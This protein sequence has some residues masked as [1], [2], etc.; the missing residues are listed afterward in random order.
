MNNASPST[1]PD[2]P[3]TPRTGLA[4]GGLAHPSAGSVPRLG[5]PGL[6]AVL[7]LCAVLLAWSWWRLEGYQIADAVEYLERAY[8]LVRGDEMID[9]QAIRSFGFSGLL[10]PLFAVAEFVG[11]D[12]MVWVVHA[13]RLFQMLLTL[14]TVACAVRIGARLGGRGVGYAAGIFLG[15]NPVL[16][17]WGVSPVSGIASALFVALATEQLLR[18]P[19]THHARRG[20]LTGLYLGAAVVMAYQTVVVVVPLVLMTLFR[21][22]KH[23]GTHPLTL[24]A[25]VLAC[26]L[27][28]CFLDLLYYGTFGRSIVTYLLE[29]IGSVGAIQVHRV[30]KFLHIDALSD[31]AKWIYDQG[32]SA[33]NIDDEYQGK[34]LRSL[35][36][37]RQKRERSW[38]L[39]NLHHALTGPGVAL[40]A[41]GVLSALRKLRWS[42]TL[43]LVAIIANVLAMNEKGS[44]DFRLWLPFLPMIAV[45]AGL[46]A[47]VLAGRTSN[48]A[49][50]S[51]AALVLAALVVLG[52]HEHSQRNTRSFGAFWRAMEMVNRAAEMPSRNGGPLHVAC[53]YHWAVFLRES[54]GVNL[55]K[56]PKHLDHWF[57]YT[58]EERLADL[59]AIASL[60]WFITH[61]PI[62]TERPR[63]MEAVNR[64]FAVRGV[65]Y[66]RREFD[67][68]G[69]IYVLAR[70]TG[71]TR[72]RAFYD[73]HEDLTAAEFATDRAPWR[74][75]AFTA[76]EEP[77]RMQLL[78]FDFGRVAGDGLGWIT[79]HW[80]GG[81]L[82]RDLTVIDRITSPS[83]DHAWQNNHE[84][85][86]GMMPTSGWPADPSTPWV[87]SES[88][89][90]V[91]EA[92]PYRPDGP[93]RLIGGSYLRGDRIPADLWFDVALPPSD[94]ADGP[95]AAFESGLQAVRPSDN[96]PVARIAPPGHAP[97]PAGY[98]TSPDGFTWVGAFAIPVRPENR[99]RTAPEPPTRVE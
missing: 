93:D 9:S 23:S 48:A 33:G 55:I 99:L 53:A 44:K 97:S 72:E 85:A 95:A 91:P 12:D 38:Y 86:Y 13:A 45:F 61:L 16:L 75:L 54:G 30:G 94:D 10:I 35:D 87:L 52:V 73:V 2:R 4:G 65:F 41:L 43:L 1:S 64:D 36:A 77:G 51:V 57:Q 56:L 7:A 29:N 26:A 40:V 24:I 89:L 25:G 92:E 67:G 20:L 96:E 17:Q 3:G 88:Y 81:E 58:E 90:V 68:L 69:P 47:G 5:D 15:A 63:L 80:T 37:V 59:E 62:L 6:R 32:A 79:Y 14:C 71:A 39:V 11:L 70:R 28:Q 50:R 49:R 31:L 83:G 98:R 19:G 34:M 21:R 60:D 18:R 78:G 42:T 74:P 82:D 22:P 66:D 84:P 27:L 46:G 8:N 76:A